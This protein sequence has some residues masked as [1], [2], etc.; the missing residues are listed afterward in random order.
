MQKQPVIHTQTLSAY[1]PKVLLQKI[2]KHRKQ[3]NTNNKLVENMEAALLFAD[4][5]GFTA[6]TEQLAQKGLQGTEELTQILNNYFDAIIQIIE[7]EGGEVVKFIGDALLV[8]FP[9]S[10]HQNKKI[11]TKLAW[12]AAQKIQLLFERKYINLTTS[13]GKTKM[14]MKISISIGNVS[15]FEVGGQLKR[16][17]CVIA[18]EAVEQMIATSKKHEAHIDFSIKMSLVAQTMLTDTEIAI[19]EIQHI[20][21]KNIQQINEVSQYML[22]FIPGPVRYWINQKQKLQTWL[23]E[24]RPMSVLFIKI[25]SIDY[26]QKKV[27]Q[28]LNKILQDIQNIVYYYQ[29]TLDKM[30]VDDKGTIVLILFGAPPFAHEDTPLRTIRCAMKLQKIKMPAPITACSFSIGI[31]SGRVFSGAVGSTT[32][33]EYTVMGDTVNLS[34]R[35]M[36]QA[37]PKTILCDFETYKRVRQKIKFEVRQPIRVKGRKGLV[38]IYEPVESAKNGRN[39]QLKQAYNLVGRKTEIKAFYGALAKIKNNKHHISIIEGEAGM[40]KTRL[41]QE[42]AYILRD[43]D[44]IGLSGAGFSIEQQT[45]Y[46]V[47]R[48][49]LISYFRI[50]NVQEIAEQENIVRNVVQQVAPKEMPRLPLLNNILNLSFEETSFTKQLDFKLKHQNLAYFLAELFK[51][52]MQERPLVLVIEDV[53]W[54]DN[55]SWLLLISILRALVVSTQRF[56]LLLTMRPQNQ[57]AIFWH[58]IEAIRLFTD[59]EE[60]SLQNLTAPES[61][62]LI[63]NRFQLLKNGLPKSLQQVVIDRAEGNPFFA[64]ELI[65]TLYDQKIIRL[66]KGEKYNQCI[67]TGK[68]DEVL[69]A[70]PTTIQGL[71][72]AR[73]DQLSSERQFIL[74][75]GA[76]IGRSFSYASLKHVL[77]KYDIISDEILKPHLKALEKVDLTPMEIPEPN[78]SYIF[79]HIIT[80]EV[81]YQTLLFQQRRILH[82]MVAEW[83]IEKYGSA[84]NIS[85]NKLSLP[86]I[87]KTLIPYLPLLAYH[88][89]QAN[90][91]EKEFFYAKHAGLFAA[92]QFANMVAINYLSRALEIALPNEDIEKYELLCMREQVYRLQANRKEQKQ[93]ILA[94]K[95]LAKKIND[96]EKQANAIFLMAKYANTVYEYSTAIAESKNLLALAKKNDVLFWQAEAYQQWGRTLRLLDDYKEAEIMLKKALIIFTNIEKE[97]RRAITLENLAMMYKSTGDYE[98]ALTYLKQTL[99]IFQQS[100]DK[101]G[102][103]N[104]LY[105]IALLHQTQG[106]FEEAIVETEQSLQIRREIG[107]YAG[108]IYSLN[109]LGV[110]AFML[111]NYEEA[112]QYFKQVVQMSKEI[113]NLDVESS[114][115]S[116]LA[117]IVGNKGAYQEAEK[118]NKAA[119]KIF[120]HLKSKSGIASMLINLASNAMTQG[121]WANAKKHAEESIVICEEIGQKPYL[122]YAINNLGTALYELGDYKKAKHSFEMSIKIEQELRNKQGESDSLVNLSL[123]AQQILE[124]EQAFRYLEKSLAIKQQLKDKLGIANVHFYLGELYIYLEEYDK[125]I[126]H[127]NNNINML[128]ALNFQH[129]ALESHFSIGYIYFLEGKKEKSLSYINHFLTDTVDLEKLEKSECSPKTYLRIFHMLKSNNHKQSKQILEALHQCLQL[130][131]AK[132]DDIVLRHSFLYKVAVNQEILEL[133][134][135]QTG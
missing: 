19:G 77:N 2:I 13:I 116:N 57:T 58:H 54:L 107:D 33:R 130:Q 10:A 98:Q 83:Y 20:D 26:S 67:I 123:V 73:I 101:I 78:L 30:V 128:N 76:V 85:K 90:N 100:G 45:P 122:S 131:A 69:Q 126:F 125:A 22:K 56:W 86:I 95:Q 23:S 4:V 103:G 112:E 104:T 118:Y 106:N 96:E 132:I 88:Y 43:S 50:E 102:E 9:T 62:K 81:A 108:K 97:S 94:I 68:L 119:L 111:G 37:L 14:G 35:L 65:F 18:G 64:E 71:I 87:A 8:W 38:R 120:Q 75:I 3:Q 80:Q 17:E 59:I 91:R 63:E 44:I 34:A 46:R 60:L 39:K 52:W 109:N 61:I 110:I 1:L 74:K 25:N 84:S 66:E 134:E 121:D 31:T 41:V 105:N 53:H 48:E 51:I 12:Q 11:V 99:E 27:H 127:L 40:G 16:C 113:G 129:K 29:G 70:L 6:L 47:W 5:S 49:I 21:W 15:L 36:A 28:H 42:L 7:A 24:L 93:D 133:Y 55:E 82:E 135:K 117:L 114:A 89:K 115:L 124:T 32:R 79:K 72:L 92:E